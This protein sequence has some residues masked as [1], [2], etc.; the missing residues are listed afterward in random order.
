MLQVT[1]AV[2]SVCYNYSRAVKSSSW[3]LPRII[4]EL[5]SL[6]EALENLESIAE[7]AESSDPVTGSQLPALKL[8]CRPEGVLTVCLTELEALK[9]KLAP[10]RWSYNMGVRGKAMVQALRW[11]LEEA[12]TKMIFEKIGRAKSILALAITADHA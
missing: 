6:R 5:K 9:N 11:P 10:P 1:S 4:E 7:Q 3:E 2:V 12:E 8:L